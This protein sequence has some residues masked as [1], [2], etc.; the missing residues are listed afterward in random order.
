MSWFALT[1]NGSRVHCTLSLRICN[2]IEV[3]EEFVFDIC[4]N[5]L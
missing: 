2:D 1:Y 5:Y 3:L 4:E